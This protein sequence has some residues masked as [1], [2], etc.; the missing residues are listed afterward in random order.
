MRTSSP[1]WCGCVMC[2]SCRQIYVTQI[3]GALSKWFARQLVLPNIIRWLMSTTG[4]EWSLSRSLLRHAEIHLVI[5]ELVLGPHKP[6]HHILSR[7]ENCPPKCKRTKFKEHVPPN[8]L[9]LKV[10]EPVHTT[11][12]RLLPA[13]SCKQCGNAS[14]LNQNKAR[15]MIEQQVVPR[16]PQPNS[17][18]TAWNIISKT[19]RAICIWDRWLVWSF[20]QWIWKKKCFALSILDWIHEWPKLLHLTGMRSGHICKKPAATADKRQQMHCALCEHC[21]EL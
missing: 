19:H 5:N 10:T 2:W 18:A 16:L 3:F 20:L 15:M 4:S 13:W 12:G 11:V 1:W 9:S 21:P 17:A 14:P 6:I 8:T 7:D